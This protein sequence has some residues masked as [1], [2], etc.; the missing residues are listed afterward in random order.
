M[1]G[2]TDFTQE[3]IDAIERAIAPAEALNST[4]NRSVR[5]A[6]PAAVPGLVIRYSYLWQIE[7]MRGRR[8]A[9]KI[10]VCGHS[11]NTR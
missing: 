4:T 2:V 11:G 1:L 5:V 6:F 8:R 7:Y 10:A 9:S 3:D